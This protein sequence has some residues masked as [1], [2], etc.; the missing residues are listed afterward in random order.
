MYRG[1]FMT[2]GRI[3]ERLRAR[4]LASSADGT[5]NVV[6]EIALARDAADPY[7][8]LAER[9]HVVASAIRELAGD[10]VA[11]HDDQEPV[12]APYIFALLA[13]EWIVSLAGDPGLPIAHMSL[14]TDIQQRSKDFDAGNLISGVVAEPLASAVRRSPRDMHSVIIHLDVRLTT[15]GARCRVR[16]EVLAI[17]ARDPAQTAGV[18]IEERAT[19]PYV[20][21]QMSG[22]AVLALVDLDRRPEPPDRAI[23]RIWEDAKIHALITES[24]ATVKA[25]AAR[26]AFSA[27]GKNITWAVVDS[28]VDISHRHFEQY[29]N[30]DMGKHAPLAHKD[31]R[32]GAVGDAGATQDACGHGTHVAG[33]IAGTW[34]KDASTKAVAIVTSLNEAG[35][36]EKRTEEFEAIAGMAPRCAIVSLRV[37]EDDATG[38]VS[39]LIRAID[40]I[41]Q[42]ND[43]GRNILVHGV[44]LSLG[45]PFDPEWFACG[46]SP[47][48][49]EV[50]RLV[51]SGV[52]VVVAAGNSGYGYFATEYAGAT[53]Q[54]ITM[55]INDPGNAEYAIT[56]GSTHRTAPHLYGVSYFS[57]KGP[58]GDGRLKPDVLAPGERIISCASLQSRTPQTV[59][60]SDAAAPKVMLGDDYSYKEDTGTSMAAPHVSGIIAGFLSIRRE[61]IGR[62]S[63]LKDILMKSATDLGRDRTFQG[64]G[65]VDLMRAIQSV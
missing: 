3:S 22:Y 55:S 10:E 50:N 20:F 45:Y 11:I 56:V 23:Y 4:L 37:L 2:V 26:I 25:D 24:V 38:R 44:N 52:A 13:I 28:G 49:I 65:L 30:V 15:A 7:A 35:A 39:A 46:Q 42:W 1:W 63:E 8:E 21:A 53:T 40:Q 43:Y 27:D 54:G 58:T 18:G 64:A 12:I 59:I 6:I 51:Q 29:C 32:P 61:Y 48:C 34:P 36:E 31:F 14:N 16:D 41:Q 9:Y 60:E 57:S 62:P 5:I 19:H 33:I 17:Q 47:I